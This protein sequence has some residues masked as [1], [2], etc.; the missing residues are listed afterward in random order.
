MH[1][2]G[3]RQVF[4]VYKITGLHHSLDSLQLSF[5]PYFREVKRLFLNKLN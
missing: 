2:Y 1:L 3:V 5:V 4:L